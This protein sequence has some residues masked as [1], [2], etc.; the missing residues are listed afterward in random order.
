M[1]SLLS[2]RDLHF[3]YPGGA[4]LLT[5]V[6]LVVTCV[7]GTSALLDRRHFDVPRIARNM[8]TGFQRPGGLVP[9]APK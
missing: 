7:D 8:R 9:K 1:V 6:D 2:A 3:A 5:G 4:P